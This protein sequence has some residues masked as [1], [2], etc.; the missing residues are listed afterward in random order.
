MVIFLDVNT[1]KILTQ[2]LLFDANDPNLIDK[3][4]NIRVLALCLISLYNYLMETLKFQ[5]AIK[6]LNPAQREAVEAIEGPVMVAAGP[7]TGKTQIL[8]LRIA[9]IL[10]Q[11]DASP[12]N[13]LALTFTE[14]G[15]VAMRRR[16]VE[17]IGTPAYRVKIST[18]HG[19]CNEIIK[20]YPEHFPAI[21]G[22][23]NIDEIGQLKIL[24]EIIFKLS[25]RRL[26]ILGNEFF[27]LK[28]INSSISK[29]K[30]EG[31]LP[32][33]LL[34]YSQKELS[35]FSK[36]D[37]LYHTNGRWAGKMK[38]AAAE[39]QKMLEKL[40]ELAEIYRAYQEN[41]RRE[42]VYDY[43]DMIL[44]VKT[45]LETDEELLLILQEQYQY[46]L[47]DEHQDTNNAQNKVLELLASFYDQPNLFVVGD[48]K[49]AIYKFQG[50]SLENFLY[51]KKKYPQAK[52][53]A[54][55]ENYRSGQLILDLAFSLL[56]GE[57]GKKLLAQNSKKKNSRIGLAE[58]STEAA[59]IFFLAKDIK[60]KIDS[61][62]KP[63]EIAIFVRD[64]KDAWPIV[65]M[66]G[67]FGVPVIL[68]SSQN[69][70]ADQEIRKLIL[71]LRAIEKLGEPALFFEFL[72][73]DFLGVQPLDIYRLAAVETEVFDLLKQP[74]K[75]AELN[76]I[77]PEKIITAFNLL[78]DLKIKSK[79]LP[80]LKF[81]E[82]AVRESGLVAD[83]LAGTEALNNIAKINSFFSEVKKIVGQKKDARLIDLIDY[84]H[85]LEEHELS[86]KKSAAAGITL[87]G[88]VRLMT[89]HRSKGLEFDHVYLAFAADGRWGN[90]RRADKIKLPVEIFSRVADENDDSNGEERRLFYVALTRAKQSLT[91][92]WSRQRVD[93]REQTP[94]I[95]LTEINPS[96]MENLSTIEIEKE[97]SQQPEIVFAAPI[98]ASANEEETKAFVREIFGK[99]GLSVT[100]LNNYLRC[101]WIYFYTNL[102]RLPQAPTSSQMY[103]IAVHSALKDFFDK[104]REDDPGK[105][106][107]LATYAD[108]LN[109]QPMTTTDYQEWL[110]RGNEYLTGYYDFWGGRFAKRSINEKK[111]NGVIL[112]NDIRLKGNL[113]KIEFLGEKQVTVVDYKT[114]KPKTRGQIE[115]TVKDGDGN[116]KRQLIFYKLLLDLSE[117]EKYQFEKGVIEFLRPDDKGQYKREEFTITKNETDDLIG[118]I[119]RVADEIVNLKFWDKRCDDPHCE[120][121]A[122]RDL[123]KK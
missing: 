70:L 119:K 28:D 52:L 115:G 36:R 14:S 75:L 56:P 60:A 45:A 118:E 77:A 57:S 106:F 83:F 42:K 33:D 59:E 40:S 13:I 105:E 48:D 110:T 31:I 81:F 37:D 44:E 114:S 69:I 101:P 15:V 30:R 111:I 58:F 78:S 94:S 20:D 85:R 91:L 87:T 62:V 12:E 34:E 93:G 50:A 55:E 38:G 11:T 10:L 29:L 104:Y 120:F 35:T 112:A 113:D 32:N 68:E 6:N 54:L 117:P 61:G 8:A 43:N 109:R 19:F 25:L 53:I 24:E 21:I 122:L 84:L 100:H 86:L 5:Q 64:N 63:E 22:A 103:G 3:T 23:I 17:L 80:L 73:L 47:V 74:D 108:Y 116:L 26:K 65:E 2:C 123:I 1:D 107:L 72:H 99:L 102:L 46:I 79:N 89:A 49:Q 76:L 66:F 71:L 51:F 92:T 88:K 97:F 41:L 95:F 96:L 18:F 27:Y 98:Q 82:V 7:G 121:C 90:K 9:N 39:E 67:R 4:T 16:L